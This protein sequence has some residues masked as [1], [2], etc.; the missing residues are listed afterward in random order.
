MYGHSLLVVPAISYK[1]PFAE[2]VNRLC[3]E[4]HTKPDAIA[5]ELGPQL[6]KECAFW[7]KELNIRGDLPCMLGIIKINRR[8]RA[9]FK[10][11][12]RDLQEKTGK[13]LNDLSPD[14]LK[15][16]LNY[17]SKSLFPLSPTDS[18]VEAIRCAIELE[19]P[20]YGVDLEET[21]DA[22]RKEEKIEDP[23]GMSNKNLRE[24]VER[25]VRY[26]EHSR[27][28][29]IDARREFAIAARLKSVLKKH[30]KVLFT[31]SLTCWG[32]IEKLLRNK[33]IRPAPIQ[34]VEKT[35]PA[36]FTRC[37]VHPLLAIYYM[38]V[39]PAFAGYYNRYRSPVNRYDKF[40]LRDIVTN[41]MLFFDDLLKKTYHKYFFNKNNVSKEDEYQTDIQKHPIFE[42]LLSN[43]CTIKLSLVPDITTMIEAAQGSMSPQFC[44]VLAETFMD[45]DWATNKDFPM[46]PLLAPLPI[47]SGSYMKVELIYPDASRSKPFYLNLLPG[48]TSVKAK[49]LIPWE[50]K[51]EPIIVDHPTPIEIDEEKIDLHQPMSESDLGPLRTWPPRDYLITA[52]SLDAM[53]IARGK[54]RRA[55]VPFQ[56]S[57]LDG[58]DIKATIRAHIREEDQIYVRDSSILERRELYEYCLDPIVWILNPEKDKDNN[59]KWNFYGDEIS[60]VKKYIINSQKLEEIAQKHGTNY[61]C[62][63]NFG[64]EEVASQKLKKKGIY[65]IISIQGI[66]YFIPP[67]FTVEQEA[68]FM[69]NN[70]YRMPPFFD[71]DIERLFQDRHKLDLKN[72][73]WPISMIQM[74]IIYAQKEVTVIIPD[75]FI[76]PRL[77]FEEARKRRIELN[78]APLSYFP[79]EN[80]EKISENFGVCTIAGSDEKEFPESVERYLGEKADENRH[81]VPRWLLNYGISEKSM[82][83]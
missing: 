82:T 30:T 15:Y 36:E 61:L 28:K 75:D 16:I 17:S 24:Y 77:V 33:E 49:V 72:T 47:Q 20:L 42:K 23:S 54:S 44:E 48:S 21:A 35:Q 14:V 65:Y 51:H 13:D 62:A 50:W 41:P 29:E 45:F 10:N 78:V 55:A 69:E 18:I 6:T 80:I 19:I 26:A 9:S 76:L 52:M 73:L 37:I 64:T 34:D 56:G 58:I 25:N 79:K 38:D 4:E 32:E 8:I 74:A 22:S 31:G 59:S 66:V 57:L 60:R 67:H 83:T 40:G 3:R 7:L 46:L 71:G 5:V 53:R 68:R 81:L 11:R 12:A 2:H 27:D 43:L 70:D 39:F 63:V 1:V